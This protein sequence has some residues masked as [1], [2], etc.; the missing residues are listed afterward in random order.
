M[1]LAVVVSRYSEELDWL[2]VFKNIS[3]PVTFY[4]FDKNDVQPID[5]A[6]LALKLDFAKIVYK[7]LPNIGREGHTYL[8]YMQKYYDTFDDTCYT[9]YCQGNIDE[10]VCVQRIH[11]LHDK[12]IMLFDYLSKILADAISS[13]Q[14]ISDWNAKNYDFKKHSATY[15]F[16]IS[17]WKGKLEPADM[18]FGPWFED[19]LGIEFPKE[20][21]WWPAALFCAR[22]DVI[23]KRPVGFYSSLQKQLMSL[24]PEKGHFLERSWYYIMGGM[25]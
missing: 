23:R 12:Q 6:S 3:Y 21:L 1:K 9:L 11:N 13:K 14:F 20:P 7:R 8:E 25:P 19:L 18:Q 22:N 24:N 10:H 17:Q 2:I 15:D 5:T 4:I 16:R